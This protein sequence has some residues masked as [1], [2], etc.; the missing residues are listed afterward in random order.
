MIA[1]HVAEPDRAA[2]ARA[3]R[4][5]RAALRERPGAYAAVVESVREGYL[6]TTASRGCWPSSTPTCAC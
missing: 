6:S 3:A 4:R 1:P 2:G 5:R